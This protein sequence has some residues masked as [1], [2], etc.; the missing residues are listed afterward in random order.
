MELTM[1]SAGSEIKSFFGM[2]DKTGLTFLIVGAVVAIA[3]LFAM[4]K[5][6]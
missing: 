1:N 5:K 3:G 4:V 6:K 2:E